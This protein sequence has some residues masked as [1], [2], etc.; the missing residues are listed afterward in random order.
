MEN[1]KREFVKDVDYYLEYGYVIF[2]EKYLK[3]KG[4][5]CGNKCR[6]CPYEPRNIKGISTLKQTTPP[7]SLN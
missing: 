4:E 7:D 2:T 1:E 6:H 3:E 5:C